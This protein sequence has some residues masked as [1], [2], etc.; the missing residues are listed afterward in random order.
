M[1]ARLLAWWLRRGGAVMI[2]ACVTSWLLP[3]PWWGRGLW[4]LAVFAGAVHLLAADRARRERGQ[5]GGRD[6]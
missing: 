1:T 2:A 6:A 3:L 5:G 4:N